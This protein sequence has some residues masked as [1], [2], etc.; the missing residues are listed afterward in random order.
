MKETKYLE[1]TLTQK[2]DSDSEL[3][4][5]IMKRNKCYYSLLK[6]FTLNRFIKEKQKLGHNR[7]FLL[8]VVLYGCEVRALTTR[9]EAMLKVFEI[10]G[11]Q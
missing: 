3:K 10:P 2:N 4:E 5:I 9:H 7:Q 8:A 11:C 6:S 1:M